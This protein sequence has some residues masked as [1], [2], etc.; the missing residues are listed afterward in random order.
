MYFEKFK[1]LKQN[2]PKVLNAIGVVHFQLKNYAKSYNYI[3]DS[4][5]YN[6]EYLPALTNL[7]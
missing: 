4:L 1:Q 2:D 3:M 6:P 5:N 7:H